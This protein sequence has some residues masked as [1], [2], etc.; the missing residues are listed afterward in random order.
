M[1]PDGKGLGDCPF[2]QHANLALTIK[3]VTLEYIYIY[4]HNKLQQ[5][6]DINP[7]GTVPVLETGD[8]KIR[9]C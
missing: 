8:Q 3:D 6:L 9:V 1:S 2:T 5:F 4:T 7:A